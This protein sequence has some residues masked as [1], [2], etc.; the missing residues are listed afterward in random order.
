VKF[1]EPEAEV[2]DEEPVMRVP[3]QRAERRIVLDDDFEVEEI[4]P[5]RYEPLERKEDEGGRRRNKSA[6]VKPLSTG[7]AYKLVP[8]LDDPNMVDSLID[9][10]KKKILEGIT[11]EMLVAMNPEYAKKLREI[12]FKTRVPIHKNFMFGTLETGSEFPF[13]EDDFPVQLGSDAIALDTLP[14]V[15]SFFIS[16]EQDEGLE[17]GCIVCLDIVLQYYSTLAEGQAPKQ[18][19]AALE[20]VSLRAVFPLIAGKEQVEC[21][22]DTGSQIVS[23]ALAVAER[24]GISWDP[25]VQIYMQSANKSL[26]KSVGLARNVPFLFGDIAVYLQVHIIDQPAY[27][28]LLGRPFDVL[29]ESLLKNFKDGKQSITICDPSTDRRITLPT[30]A[31]GTFTIVKS[32]SRA[33]ST[34]RIEEVEDNDTKPTADTKETETD[35]Q[36]S[37]RN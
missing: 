32:P 5:I 23:M 28:V 4:P 17:P 6:V 18:I 3:K 25:D 9:Q 1:V 16:T 8:K 20:S 33:P 10:T 13:M 27:Q 31:R 26:K 12:T 30:H 34:A 36:G 21:V 7:K 19:Y 24:L 15:D 2:E 22:L 37:S 35:F 14:R 29:T 11:V